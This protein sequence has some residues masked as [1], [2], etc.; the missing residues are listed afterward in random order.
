MY[1]HIDDDTILE[2]LTKRVRF[3]TDD[4]D[5]AD[6]FNAYYEKQ[7]E[8]QAW[9]GAD[10]D[11]QTIVDNDYINNFEYGTREDIQNMFSD[12]T[13]DKICAEVGDLILYDAH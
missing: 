4:D 12:F 6:L 2:M 5:V 7:V 13:E 3:W 1:I 9:N 10:F 8:Q 11:V